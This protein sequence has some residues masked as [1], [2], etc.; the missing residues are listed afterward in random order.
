MMFSSVPYADMRVVE[1][2]L[3]AIDYG[4]YKQSLALSQKALKR[5]GLENSLNLRVTC[6]YLTQHYSTYTIF[7][8]LI[9]SKGVF[10][11]ETGPARRSSGHLPESSKRETLGRFNSA[12]DQSCV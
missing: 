11:P 4:N 8:N 12:I 3:D 10:P 9:G 2:I 7:H 6:H 5:K 1:P